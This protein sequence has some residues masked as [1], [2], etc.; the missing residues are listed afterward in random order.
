LLFIKTK[1]I[2][3]HSHNS[4]DM[5]TLITQGIRISVATEFRNELSEPLKHHYFFTYRI[6]IENK[7]NAPVQLLK[8]HWFIFD[9]LGTDH[10]V[11]GDGVIGVQ[12]LIYPGEMYEY[13]SA[14]NLC[15]DYGKMNGTYLMENKLTKELF[16]VEIPE[17][18]LVVPFKFN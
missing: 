5:V 8:R 7:N 4:S 16:N 12:P 9:S 3:A 17:F 13:E 10:E 6:T 11:E 15:S 18:N 2:I 14:C 1:P